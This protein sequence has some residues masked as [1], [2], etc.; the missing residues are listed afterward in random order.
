MAVRSVRACLG[1]AKSGV[2]ASSGCP[3]VTR[4]MG[5][6]EI[7]VSW[8][9]I[10]PRI[11]RLGRFRCSCDGKV[12]RIGRERRISR[13]LTPIS[14]ISSAFAGFLRNLLSHEIENHSESSIRGAES[15]HESACGD[16]SRVRV[17]AHR[18]HAAKW[19]DSTISWFL[20]PPNLA[21]TACEGR[22]REPHARVDAADVPWLHRR[23]D[24]IQR[25]ISS[26]S[27]D[28]GADDRACRYSRGFDNRQSDGDAAHGW[29]RHRIWRYG[30]E[31]ET[32][33]GI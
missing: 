8:R 27:M 29:A 26:Q 23:R 32:T 31:A 28:A 11:H 5:T 2:F 16:E 19:T 10:V 24:P 25:R 22:T 33:D 4:I 6:G 7:R 13:S 18:V 17:T 9:E 15:C 30:H 14:A 20:R 1:H 21:R 12:T 3:G